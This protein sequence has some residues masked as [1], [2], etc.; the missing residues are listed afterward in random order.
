MISRSILM[1]FRSEKNREADKI[2]GE[3]LCV[4]L[5]WNLFAP[6]NLREVSKRFLIDLEHF[7]LRLFKFNHLYQQAKFNFNWKITKFQNV[8]IKKKENKKALMMNGNLFEF[9]YLSLKLFAYQQQIK[10]FK[11]DFQKP[12]Q[13][14]LSHS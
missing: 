10:F 7:H 8:Q 4:V 5:N 14:S 2:Y 3:S 11:A 6:K 13:H 1:W 12:T 9:Q